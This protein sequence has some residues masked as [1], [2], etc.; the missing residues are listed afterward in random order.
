MAEYLIVS[1]HEDVKKNLCSINALVASYDGDSAPKITDQ[2]S[3]SGE[4]SSP[5][6]VYFSF[7]NFTFGHQRAELAFWGKFNL[8]KLQELSDKVDGDFSSQFD[9][10]EAHN[11]QYM[12]KSKLKMKRFV[13]FRDAYTKISGLKMVRSDKGRDF[14]LL[15]NMVHFLPYVV[16]NKR[17]TRVDLKPKE[18]E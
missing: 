18:K 1:F 13:G 10:S 12:F 16:G 5:K 14:N 11:L 15:E 4:L 6:H 17:I 3:V 2:F 9:L 7:E 8:D